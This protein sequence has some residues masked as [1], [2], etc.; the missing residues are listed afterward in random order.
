MA[1]RTHLV[2]RYADSSLNV[3]DMFECRLQAEDLY[4]YRY[5]DLMNFDNGEIATFIS[6][7]S[8]QQCHEHVS[9]TEASSILHQARNDRASLLSTPVNAH[10]VFRLV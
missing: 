9:S 5:G 8:F 2:V 4:N 3:L 10:V 6:S 1:A 7:G